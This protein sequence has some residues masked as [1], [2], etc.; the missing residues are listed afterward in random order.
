MADMQTIHVKVVVDTTELRVWA[1]KLADAGIH[2]PAHVLYQAAAQGESLT[3]QAIR[4]A[5][6]DAWDEGHRTGR[7]V[8]TNPYRKTQ[9]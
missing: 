7:V 3:E 1:D 9:Q 8:T 4:E 2:G 5:K 6:A